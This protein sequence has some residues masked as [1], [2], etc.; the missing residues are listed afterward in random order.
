[1]TM[2]D[3]AQNMNESQPRLG[4]GRI[5]SILVLGSAALAVL[6]MLGS[7]Q[8]ERMAWKEGLLSAIAQR[9]EKPA[10]TIDDIRDARDRGEAIDYDPVA[11]RGRFDHSGERYFLA[12]RNGEAGWH[13]YT[14]LQ[15]EGS[16]RWIF[17]NRGFVPYA[18]KDPASRMAG[19]PVGTMDLT[20]LA[21]EAPIE[22][23]GS[24]LPD[25]D[26]SQNV[27]FWR[28][29]SDMAKGLSLPADKVLPFFVDA[30]PGAAEGGYPIGGVTV[31][32][33][34][35]NHLQYAITWFSLAAA[36]FVML[37][38]FVRHLLRGRPRAPMG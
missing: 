3:A 11:L 21:R 4:R 36:L 37:A 17:V 24:F 1:M 18:M 23:P 35:N 32:D 30:G 27:F 28:S 31:V 22:K 29:V 7:W 20:G 25:N 13:A 15:I 38:L 9:I 10:Q 14:P 2:P 33:L 34:P 26:P 16:D 19:N 12:T 5:I 6:V 8:L